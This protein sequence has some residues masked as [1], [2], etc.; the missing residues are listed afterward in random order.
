ME[1]NYIYGPRAT[2]DLCMMAIMLLLAVM[3]TITLLLIL[4]RRVMMMKISMER[5]GRARARQ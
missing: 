1:K 2:I 3:M 5:W 4:G